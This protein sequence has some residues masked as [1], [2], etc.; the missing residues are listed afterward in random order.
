MK[1]S[2]NNEQKMG[3]LGGVGQIFIK[4]WYNVAK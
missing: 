4:H 2:Y 1:E 3:I